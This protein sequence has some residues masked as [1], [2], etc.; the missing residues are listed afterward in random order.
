MTPAVTKPVEKPGEEII[1]WPAEAELRTQQLAKES[2]AR[3]RAW[4]G[5]G[6][7]VPRDAPPSFDDCATAAIELD[8]SADLSKR[9][10]AA[11]LAP[12]GEVGPLDAPPA[13]IAYGRKTDSP[14][15][16]RIKALLAAAARQNQIEAG[17][18][19][20][21]AC[22]WVVKMTPAHVMRRLSRRPEKIKATMVKS[23]RTA[24]PRK[25]RTASAHLNF[26]LPC[27]AIMRVGP[28][29]GRTRSP[30]RTRSDLPNGWQSPSLNWPIK[31]HLLSRCPLSFPRDVPEWG[32]SR[33]GAIG[34]QQWTSGGGYSSAAQYRFGGAAR[35]Q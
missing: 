4:G 16:E 1:E 11:E 3:W 15:V 35:R 28:L 32:M 5:D 19:V 30:L 24:L 20:E 13:V 7:A 17:A 31:S 29:A 12:G 33:G 26:S 14:T 6:A 21:Q 9:L 2:A 25:R 10:T 34:E 23:G 27:G 22:K 8:G 18:S